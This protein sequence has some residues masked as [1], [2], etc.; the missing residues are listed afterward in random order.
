MP[1]LPEHFQRGFIEHELKAGIEYA[2]HDDVGITGDLYIPKGPGKFPAVVAVHGGGWQLGSSL[3]HRG[4]GPYLAQRGIALFSVN[5]RLIKDGRKAYPEAV[6]DVRAGVQFL[7]AQGAQYHIDPERLG[8]TGD[9]AGAH[10]AALVALAGDKAPFAGAYP[11]SPLAAISTAVKACIGVYGVYDMA[12]QWQHDLL[13]RPGDNIAQK[14]LGASLVED[15]KLYFESSPVSYATRDRNQ[16]AFLLAWG[17]EDDTVN[18]DTQSKAFLLA[19]KQAGYFAR[20][21]VLQGAPH[22]WNTEPMDEPGSF[23]GFLA[24]RALRFLQE[25]L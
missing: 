14:F 8:I 5:Y 6:H 1:G 20:P 15:R 2:K 7:R 25:K 12:A 21:A 23:S 10:L 24:P 19:L 4:W 16:T 11:D 3:F 22:F 9:S 18:P 13:H 17:S